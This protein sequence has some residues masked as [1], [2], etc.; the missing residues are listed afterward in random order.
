MQ[1][2]RVIGEYARRRDDS[3][4][5]DVVETLGQVAGGTNADLVVICI[6]SAST[7]ESPNTTVP[8]GCPNGTARGRRRATYRAKRVCS[9]HLQPL[10]RR[11]IA[12]LLDAE[13]ETAEPA[14]ATSGPNEPLPP[15]RGLSLW[16]TETDASGQSCSV[17]LLLQAGTTPMDLA[18]LHDQVVDRG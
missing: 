4:L 15:T 5:V 17:E 13:A 2:Y 18:Q 16:A 14:E 9:R 11:D 7:G 3:R 6:P 12:A 10:P 8:S 1:P